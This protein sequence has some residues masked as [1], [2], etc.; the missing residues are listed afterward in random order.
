MCFIVFISHSLHWCY[1]KIALREYVIN[2]FEE[3]E[4]F[5]EVSHLSRA[6]FAKRLK[7]CLKRLQS[8]VQAGNS[9]LANSLSTHEK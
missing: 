9:D 5:K 7:H 2:S 8:V 6:T 3:Y 1:I 4:I